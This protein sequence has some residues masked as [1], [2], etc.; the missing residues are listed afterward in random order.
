[1][2]EVLPAHTRLSASGAKRWMNCS[3]S[4]ALLAAG[5]FPEDDFDDSEWSS[6]GTDAH[7]LGSNCLVDGSDPW[8]HLGETLPLG[9]VVDDKMW[10]GVQVYV[11]YCRKRETESKDWIWKTEQRVD[12]RTFHPDFGGTA[13][14]YGV[15]NYWLEVIDYKNGA[16]VTVDV[17]EN[18]QLMYYGY[19]IL[20]KYPAVK[21]VRLTI[22]QPNG[23]HPDGPIRSWCISAEDL[24]AWAETKLYPAMLKVDT[25]DVELV[26]GDWCQFCP[27]KI[28]CPLLTKNAATLAA[29]TTQPVDLT[30]ERLAE[31][32]KMAPPVMSLFKS[33]KQEGE[34]RL[35]LGQEI[36]G[37]K[38]VKQKAD[39]VWKD[40]AEAKVVEAFGEDAY[41]PKKL[42]SPAQIEELP[43][44]KATVA[45]WAYKPDVGLAIAP[46]SDKRAAQK[47]PSA[48]SIF[49]LDN[50]PRTE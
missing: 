47:P 36:D 33:L 6:L 24:R 37:Q 22:V 8:Q 18:E 29:V 15:G 45:E 14:R 7:T 2:T 21:D 48:A 41:V 10:E 25:K 13:D 28:R 34:R 26:A 43:D 4:V 40:G 9:H 16:G 5:H 31:L 32:L 12:D 1:M 23:Y 46:L 35:L 27:R 19:G 3:G 30:D 17:E 42:K 39:R 11:D 44:G 50:L 38:L 20:R 49:N